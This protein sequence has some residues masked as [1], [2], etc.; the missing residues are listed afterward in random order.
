MIN[1]K[2]TAPGRSARGTQLVQVLEKAAIPLTFLERR[3]F[4]EAEGQNILEEAIVVGLQQ[5]DYASKFAAMASFNALWRYVES[6]DVRLQACSCKVTFRVAGDICVVDSST[7]RLLELVSSS[8]RS[9][10]SL[11]S[12]RTPQELRP[13]CYIAFPPVALWP[14]WEGHALDANRRF[15]QQGVGGYMRAG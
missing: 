13:P 5:A 14:G 2:I 1:V 9:L 12:C 15:R 11:F 4:D 3:H 7:A 6:G 8:R 10:M